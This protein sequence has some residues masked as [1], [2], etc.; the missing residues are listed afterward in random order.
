MPVCVVIDCIGIGS[1][2][3]KCLMI[4]LIWHIGIKKRIYVGMRGCWSMY[5]CRIPGVEVIVEL[6]GADNEFVWR[7]WGSELWRDEEAIWSA[8]SFQ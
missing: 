1:S 8:C 7:W 4:V 6:A 5:T 3:N 2:V